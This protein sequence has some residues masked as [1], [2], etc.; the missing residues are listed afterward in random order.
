M[1]AENARSIF[2]FTTEL[3]DQYIIKN[4]NYTFTIHPHEDWGYEFA[5]YDYF[6]F[7]EKWNKALEASLPILNE[8]KVKRG[9]IPA[10][11]GV[12]EDAHLP[13]YHFH[14]FIN[15]PRW[16]RHTKH[17]GDKAFFKRLDIGL[18][19]HLSRYTSIDYKR[20][21]SDKIIYGW[22]DYI[23]ESNKKGSYQCRDYYWERNESVTKNKAAKK[24]HDS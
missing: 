13:S 15:V 18:W 9:K 12:I 14:G 10:I 19:K 3:T 23:G 16:L 2:E 7:M 11:A 4:Y 8:N 5:R 22:R 17:G 1:S 24:S 6:D 21:R 20:Q